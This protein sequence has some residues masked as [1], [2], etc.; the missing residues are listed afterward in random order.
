M[1]YGKK[2]IQLWALNIM[3]QARLVITKYFMALTHEIR[4]YTSILYI[5]PEE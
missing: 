4:D 3:F 2:T 1:A 5:L